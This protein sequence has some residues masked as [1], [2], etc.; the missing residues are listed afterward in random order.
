MVAR[1][2]LLLSPLALLA[3][4][5]QRSDGKSGDVPREAP[6]KAEAPGA[7]KAEDGRFSIKGPG[8]DLK[9]N[10]PDGLA[11]RGSDS[12]ENDLL[13]PGAAVSGMH[14]EA[15]EKSGNGP[16]SGVELRFT[17]PDAPEKVAAWYRDPGRASGFTV[18]SATQDGN[19]LLIAGQ[20]KN[21]KDPFMLRLTPRSGRGT[22]GRLTLSDG[23]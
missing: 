17:T 5:D 11:N 10:I 18:S 9:V 2:A 12:G 1:N 13:Y 8:F 14:I 21:G 6:A 23:G 20:Q 4:C 16:N 19:A 3:A 22:D 7:G 15:Q